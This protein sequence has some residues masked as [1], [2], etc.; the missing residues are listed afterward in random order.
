MEKRYV[1]RTTLTNRSEISTCSHTCRTYYIHFSSFIYFAFWFAFIAA[2]KQSENKNETN[3]NTYHFE[4]CSSK[5]AKR[6]VC[7]VRWCTRTLRDGSF[8]LYSFINWTHSCL[9]NYAKKI[10]AHAAKRALFVSRSSS[11]S[12]SS[13]MNPTTK[14]I[15]IHPFKKTKK[16]EKEDTKKRMH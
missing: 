6:S 15:Y 8:D 9:Q 12:A 1:K 10:H 5:N 2:D 16:N 4:M 14:A 13:L 3:Q 11:L 7:T